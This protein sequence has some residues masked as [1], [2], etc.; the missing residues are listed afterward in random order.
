MQDPV[1]LRCLS[2]AA[3]Q[4]LTTLLP[5]LYGLHILAYHKVLTLERLLAKCSV[6]CV[7][8]AH[9]LPVFLKFDRASMVLVSRPAVMTERTCN[10]CATFAITSN[11]GLV[12]LVHK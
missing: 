10:A 7:V 8:W 9:R 4:Q 1:D 11:R 2:V 6:L 5:L 12:K 3:M